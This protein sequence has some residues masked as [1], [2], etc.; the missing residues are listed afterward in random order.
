MEHEIRHTAHSMRDRIV[1][2]GWLEEN[3]VQWEMSLFRDELRDIRKHNDTPSIWQPPDVASY[4]S[5]LGFYRSQ[6]RNHIGLDIPITVA[7]P[8]LLH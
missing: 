6:G 4:G 2:R 7:G 3:V 8:M 5:P 1:K